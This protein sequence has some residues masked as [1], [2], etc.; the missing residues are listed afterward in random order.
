[1][2]KIPIQRIS[3]EKLIDLGLLDVTTGINDKNTQEAIKTFQEKA[4]LVVDGM[5]GDNTFSKLLFGR[6]CI[7]SL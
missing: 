7:F 5:V 3:Q 6:E 1:M 4:G 2:K